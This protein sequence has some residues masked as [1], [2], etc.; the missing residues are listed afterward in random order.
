MCGDS[1]KAGPSEGGNRASAQAAAS[2]SAKEPGRWR[3]EALDGIARRYAQLGL[4]AECLKTVAAIDNTMARH[5][6][7]AEAAYSFAE[8]KQFAGRLEI[9]GR[10]DDASHRASVL[11]DC[12]NT[13]REWPACASG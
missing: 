9:T 5:R 10:I 1:G 8:A 13:S 11:R 7:Q 6:T 3:W 12:D 2:A 4:A